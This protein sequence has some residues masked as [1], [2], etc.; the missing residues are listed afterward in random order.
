MLVVLLLFIMVEGGDDGAAGICGAHEERADRCIGTIVGKQPIA[1]SAAKMESFR[2]KGIKSCSSSLSESPFKMPA[3][4]A[5]A[6]AAAAAAA[7]AL[8]ASNGSGF[9]GAGLFT[10]A[11]LG[12]LG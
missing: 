2:V 9:A 4:A 7:A 5:E 3:D 12:G 6:A 8:A 11:G 10:F 1:F